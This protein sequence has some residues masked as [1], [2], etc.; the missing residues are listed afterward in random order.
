MA[1]GVDA[2]LLDNMTP[3]QLRE[4]V[5]IVAGRAITEASGRVTPSTAAEIAASGVDLISVGWCTHSAPTL[6][7]GLDMRS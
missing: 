5:D 3:D 4:A 2:V 7:I 1:I 6:D